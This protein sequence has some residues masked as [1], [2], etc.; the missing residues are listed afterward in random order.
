M[1]RSWPSSAPA[2]DQDVDVRIVGVPVIDGDPIEP[3]AEIAFDV[4]HQLSDEAAH[5]LKFGRI[6][7]RDDEPEMVPVIG[8]ALGKGLFIGRVRGGVEHPRIGAVAGDAVALQIS[9]VLGQ[10]C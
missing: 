3:G 10:R 1:T 7:G 8:G 4:L 9:D 6:L 5:V 2:A